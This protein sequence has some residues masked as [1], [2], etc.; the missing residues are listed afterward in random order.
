MGRFRAKASG[1]GLTEYFESCD[2]DTKFENANMFHIKMKCEAG[3][4]IDLKINVPN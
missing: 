3:N 4:N 2:A 1:V